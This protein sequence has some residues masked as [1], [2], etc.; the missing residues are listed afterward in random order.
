MS[1]T[2][3]RPA[4]P[5]PE[6]AQ[7][8][9]QPSEELPRRRTCR[10]LIERGSWWFLAPL[11]APLVVFADALAGRRLLAPGDGG[12]LF[13]P[14]HLLVARIFREGALPG[15]NPFSFSGSALLASAQAGVFYPP[16]LAFLFLSPTLANNVT[17]VLSF[18]I[19]GTGA[20]AFTRFLSADPA[21]AAV[22]G[23]VFAFSGFMF[24]HIG[25][26]NMI[27]S[28]AWFPWAFLGFELL[29][30]RLS[31]LHLLG[32]GAALALVLL[33]GHPQML[34]VALMA[35]GVYAVALCILD[36]R[37][38][39]ARPLVVLV[40]MVGTALG[41]AAVQLLPTAAILDVSDRSEL[42]FEAAT[43]YSFSETHLPLLVFPYL[44]GN[45]VPLAP[46]DVAYQ[47]AFE[48]NLTELAD[49][50]SVV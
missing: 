17:V 11:L 25:H 48:T 8:P 23:L 4:I 41:L 12:S 18:V 29:R 44:F 36:R 49:R 38:S 33:A 30:R 16:N 22:A 31:A 19:A 7:D 27:A 3:A 35:L 15:W 50:K 24:G 20:Y 5:V 34:S 46:F 2:P 21:G 42:S 28:L 47:G 10:R 37:T 43:T 45:T 13:L 6:V 14:L 39:V 32:A 1:T 9:A 40:V 26:Q